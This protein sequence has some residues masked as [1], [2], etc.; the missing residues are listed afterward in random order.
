MTTKVIRGFFYFVLVALLVLPIS[1]CKKRGE[2]GQE[3]APKPTAIIGDLKVVHA[4][5]QGPT[6]AG[7]MAEQLVAIFDHAMVPL[8]EI[9]EGDGTS[10]LK[11]EPS[12]AG[13]FR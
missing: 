6:S 13:K 1:Q 11:V 3:G 2:T 9:P 10:F 12:I 7:H 4:S 8:Q 5:P